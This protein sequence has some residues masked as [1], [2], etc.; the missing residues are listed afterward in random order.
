MK[1]T[2]I[3][4]YVHRVHLSFVHKI[5]LYTEYE[6]DLGM[7]EKMSDAEHIR[8]MIADSNPRY[9][10]LLTSSEVLNPRLSYD[11]SRPNDYRVF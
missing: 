7:F 1:R 10:V 2:N 11:L 8:R 4:K 6:F 5:E 3:P 9:T